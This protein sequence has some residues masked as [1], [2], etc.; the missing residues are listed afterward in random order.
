MIGPVFLAT[1]IG[2]NTGSSFTHARYLEDR[3]GVTVCQ[4]KTVFDEKFKDIGGWSG[5]AAY[6]GAGVNYNTREPIFATICC[7]QRQVGKATGQ[8]VETALE[9]GKEVFT[10]LMEEDESHLYAVYRFHSMDPENWKSGWT[11]DLTEIKEKGCA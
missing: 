2:M 6:V 1:P 9:A 3:W 5:Y 10:L 8:I 11:L 4:A 7:V